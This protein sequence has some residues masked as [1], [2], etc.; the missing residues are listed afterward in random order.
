MRRSLV[1]FLLA[2]VAAVAGLVLIVIASSNATAGLLADD[3]IYLLMA[4][5][6]STALG[7][8]DSN[9]GF[10]WRHSQFP[11]LYP[12]VI[13]MLGGN[14][15]HIAYAHGLTASMTVVG[16]VLAYFWMRSKA[17]LSAATCVAI[18]AWW[19]LMPKT[20]FASIE[21]MSEPLYI[22]FTYAALT[23]YERADGRGRYFYAAAA[24]VALCTLTRTTGIALA[25]A[26][27]LCTWY[28]LQR[29]EW[30]VVATVV[31]IPIG[32]WNLASARFFGAVRVYV[33]EPSQYFSY[34]SV[35]GILNALFVGWPKTF[36]AAWLGQF[37]TIDIPAVRIIC[38]ALLCCAVV[39]WVRRLR[40]TNLDAIYMALYMLLIWIW[41]YP[42]HIHRFI[43]PLMPMLMFYAAETAAA[44]VSRVS[45]GSVALR[46]ALMLVAMA[47]ALPNW[48]VLVQRFRKDLPVDLSQY[49]GSRFNLRTDRSDEAVSNILLFREVASAIARAGALVPAGDC[50]TASN[51]DLM[52]LY[53]RRPSVFP[54]LPALDDATFDAAIECRYLFIQHAMSNP[55]LPDNYPAAR[56]KLKELLADFSIPAAPAPV[57]I[58][59]LYRIV[60]P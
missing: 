40:R 24:L 55:Y 9:T 7:L 3:A 42:D 25:A 51:R 59:T 18:V 48:A 38:A 50:V 15:G 49:A 34:S 17:T 11:P 41:P 56:V 45:A 46:N 12:L 23:L 6:F 22:C 2:V 57:A 32:L 31:V 30:L 10:V 19:L 33:R 14:A 5:W 47:I 16:A 29:R 1:W 58:G 60:R 28:R 54:P 27:V 4:E 35:E 8:S 26:F 53:G 13:G 20:V 44:A 36:W 39:G 21:A 37:Q 52:M 43:W